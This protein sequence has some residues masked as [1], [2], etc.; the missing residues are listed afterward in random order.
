MSTATNAIS[1]NLI[2]KP[3]KLGPSSRFYFHQ[4]L[5]SSFADLPID[6]ATLKL[7]PSKHSIARALAIFSKDDLLPITLE[8]SSTKLGL[9]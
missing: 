3:L 2:Q 8:R 5:S 9:V 1:Y 4:L 6:G 7:L